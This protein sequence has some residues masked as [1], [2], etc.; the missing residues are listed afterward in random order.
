MK[1]TV[2]LLAVMICL[3]LAIS[4][5]SCGNIDEMVNEATAPLNEKIA[6]LTDQIAELQGKI[7]ALEG[8]NATLKSEKAALEKE[9]AELEAE[10]AELE[11]E[12]AALEEELEDL[13]VV[14]TI[15]GISFNSDSAGYDADTNTFT[16]SEENPFVLTVLGENLSSVSLENDFVIYLYIDEVWYV[17]DKV[18]DTDLHS[19]I[20]EEDKIEYQFD[21]SRTK[22]LADVYGSISGIGLGDGQ[23]GALIDCTVLDMKLVV[24]DTEDGGEDEDE[25]FTVTTA[26]ELADAFATY[27]Y[28]RLGADIE[29]LYG[30][31]VSRSVTLDLAG[32]DLKVTTKTNPT[33]WVYLNMTIINSSE[34]VSTLYREIVTYSDST[35]NISGNVSIEAPYHQINGDGSIDLTGYTGQNILIYTERL[36]GLVIPEGYAFYNTL[37]EMRS[38]EYRSENICDIYIRPVAT[39]VATE[40]ELAAA[41][42]MGGHILL[43]ENIT[44]ENML[45]T[46]K[47]VFINLGENILTMAEG[48]YLTIHTK[49]AFVRNGTIE[50]SGYCAALMSYTDN[51]LVDACTLI[52]YDYFALYCSSGEAT[53]KNTALIG[54]VCVSS[55][56]GNPATAYI[57]D[58]N[59]INVGSSLGVVVDESGVLITSFDPTDM[60]GEAYNKGTVTDNG[61]GTYTVRVEQ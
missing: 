15:T 11:A 38:E 29:S 13:I 61:D 44:V 34:D 4:L 31:D 21:F 49:N 56:Y 9:K 33:F 24:D 20:I 60:L 47:D 17:F 48:T 30:Y 22:T 32:Y 10:K 2:K 7:N 52:S 54:G 40:A 53:V 41:L 50:A 51:L 45:H 14:P 37:N 35:L 26:G 18:F 57:L 28:I 36:T 6:S 58:N 46:T 27:D 5:A 3:L 1:K 42:E 8:E 16:V 23:T 19:P 43:T 25:F 12:K 39:E 59:V 55:S